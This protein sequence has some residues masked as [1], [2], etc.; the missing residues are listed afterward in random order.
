MLES[1]CLFDLT[2]RDDDE[3]AQEDQNDQTTTKDTSVVGVSTLDNDDNNINKKLTV[4]I[5]NRLDDDDTTKATTTKQVTYEKFGG[6]NNAKTRKSKTK[7]KTSKN[8][9]EMVKDMAS[10]EWNTSQIT[11]ST[12]VNKLAKQL[13]QIA[14]S[15]EEAPNVRK[16]IKFENDEKFYY[17]DEET[18][19]LA[20]QQN[21]MTKSRSLSSARS[22]MEYVSDLKENADKNNNKYKVSSS[23]SRPTIFS[24]TMVS[25]SSSRS[26]SAKIINILGK[27][28]VK[29]PAELECEIKIKKKFDPLGIQTVDC[30]YDE[31]INGCLVLRIEPNTACA[32]DNRLKVGDY[33]LS[34]NNEQMKNLTNSTAKGILN[35]ASL[36]SNDVV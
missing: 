20:V 8:L 32:R 24:S 13:S 21:Q 26:S 2:V 19:P 29:L 9:N 27:E 16:Q 10:F 4:R 5:D 7:L 28:I 17:R 11:N 14:T 36:T 30:L 18:S 3:N 34:V 35:R 33:L 31:G 22:Y 15:N 6:L 1:N 25:R 23:K 12:N